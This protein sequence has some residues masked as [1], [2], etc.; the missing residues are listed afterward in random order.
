MKNKIKEFIKSF[1]GLIIYFVI[2]MGSSL[3]FTEQ[4]K[5]GSYL[6]VNIII[7][8]TEFLTLFLLIYINR[9]RLKNDFKDFDHNYKKYLSFGIKVWIIGILGMAIS[10]TIINTYFINTIA[11]NEEAD[12]AILNYYPLYSTIAM[13]FI[14]PFIEEL[15]F[16]CGFK[17]HI[18]NK[19]LYYIITVGIFASVHVLNGMTSLIELLYF[20]PYGILAF[21]LSYIYDKT[22]NIYT[23]TIIHTLHNALTIFILISQMMLG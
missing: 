15:A 23:T 1:Y 3:L 20:I 18:K 4:I 17:D 8:G 16:R 9:K 19:T 21:A 6:L 5:N 14:G 22:D 13:I 7:I 12:R 2:Q 10:N 11:S